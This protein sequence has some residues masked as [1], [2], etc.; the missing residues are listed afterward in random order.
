MPTYKGLFLET[1]EVTIEADGTKAAEVEF[2]KYLKE[3][4][5]DCKILSI[6]QTDP[7]IPLDVPCPHCKE[8]RELL[9][10]TFAEN[11]KQFDEAFPVDPNG[12]KVA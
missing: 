7:V 8:D 6:V 11:V 4:D 1:H 2:A 10:I 3:K 9:D 12:P 5:G